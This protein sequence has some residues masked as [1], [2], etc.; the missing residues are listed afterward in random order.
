MGIEQEYY[1]PLYRLAISNVDEEY[2]L[3]KMTEWL[4]KNALKVSNQMVR[5]T[6]K[7]AGR[8]D[9]ADYFVKQEDISVGDTVKSRST[10]RFGTV[11]KEHWDGETVSVKW[12]TGGVQPVSKGALFKMHGKKEER[13]DKKDIAIAKSDMDTYESMTDKKKV[14]QETN[15]KVEQPLKNGKKASTEEYEKWIKEKLTKTDSKNA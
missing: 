7:K 2:R 10:A 12:E 11:V 8:E 6:L 3:E 1:I 5:R 9:L 13:F 4:A 14:D 15:K